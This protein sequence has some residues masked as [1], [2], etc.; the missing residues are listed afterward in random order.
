VSDL[1]LS[2]DPPPRRSRPRWVDG[3]GLG[4][5]V[6]GIVA[7]GVLGDRGSSDRTPAPATTTSTTSPF[8]RGTHYSSTTT[9]PEPSTTVVVQ[10]LPD[11]GIPEPTRSVV[12]LSSGGSVILVDV[13]RATVERLPVASGGGMLGVDEGFVLPAGDR[14]QVLPSHGL[15]ATTVEVD[16]VGLLTGQLLASGPHAFWAVSG[17]DSGGRAVEL[18]TAGGRTG[19][20]VEVPSGH[21]VAGVL[22][23]GLVLG[24][25]GSLTFVDGT[26]G[27]RRALG[28]G[29]LLAVGGRWIVRQSCEVLV[30]RVELVETTTGQARLLPALPAEDGYLQ[31]GKLSPDGRWLAASFAQGAGG[32]RLSVVHLADRRTWTIEV[33]GRAP[34]EFSP[35][36]KVL[37]VPR[38]GDLCAYET[39]SGLPHC[40]AISQPSVLMLAVAPAP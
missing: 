39:S 27:R 26:T 24:G 36:G 18:D 12:L 29:D 33:D 11:A 9:A 21:Y 22:D 6:L 14:F 31:L 30:C 5:L 1:F 3:I 10:Q 32:L 7:I 25:H 37:F 34:F 20:R 28:T 2:D 15:P 16:E 35:D 4:A 38:D 8:R 17:G 23:A 13:D 19:R 40:L